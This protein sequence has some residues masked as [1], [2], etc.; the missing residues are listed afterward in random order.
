M[1][2]LALLD[3]LDPVEFLPEEFQPIESQ[4]LVSTLPKS[5]V[6]STCKSFKYTLYIRTSISSQKLIS[7][8]SLTTSIIVSNKMISYV[9]KDLQF[10][11]NEQ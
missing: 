3:Q 4:R 10:S 11:T 1:P 7:S 8:L 2:V 5:N 9:F 6:L